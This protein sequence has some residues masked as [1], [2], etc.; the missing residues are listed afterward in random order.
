MVNTSPGPSSPVVSLLPVFSHK[1]V[2]SICVLL[3][4]NPLLNVDEVSGAS[5]K[6]DVIN[7]VKDGKELQK[8][9]EEKDYVAVLWC[10]FLWGLKICFW[11]FS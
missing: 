11:F 4:I 8:L 5:K 6:D 2:I 9:I 3:L 7:D 10:K 1:L